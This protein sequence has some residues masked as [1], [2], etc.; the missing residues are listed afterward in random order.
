MGEGAQKENGKK[1]LMLPA[2]IVLCVRKEKLAGRN[3]ATICVVGILL[4]T[5]IVVILMMPSTSTHT[6]LSLRL[7][8]IHPRHNG[9]GSSSLLEQ[10]VRH[11]YA[12]AVLAIRHD[13]NMIQTLEKIEVSR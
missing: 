6:R 7:E 8:H 3:N 10:Q 4:V 11:A 5:V 12:G 9:V 1:Q 2:V 13:P